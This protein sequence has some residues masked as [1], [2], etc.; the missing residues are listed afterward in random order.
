MLPYDCCTG[1][2]T[3]TCSTDTSGHFTVT[4]ILS[5]TY[6]LGIKGSNTLSSCFPNIGLSLGVN[7]QQFGGAS[8]A[9][10]GNCLRGGD[11]NGNDFVTGADYSLLSATFLKCAGD[12]GF[13]PAADFNGNGCIQGSDYSLLST[14][15]LQQGDLT[16]P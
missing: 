4:D 9:V 7:T 15:Y 5:G 8:C 10:P 2:G 6:D 3:G 14:H 1:S 12:S 16:L 11:A 13:N